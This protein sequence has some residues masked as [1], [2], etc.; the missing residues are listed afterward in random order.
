MRAPVAWRTW[1]SQAELALRGKTALEPKQ[2]GVEGEEDEGEAAEE[3][4]PVVA[5]A[6]VFELVEENLMQL[7]R[8]Q[9]AE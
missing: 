3:V 9:D 8:G 7:G 2:N 1:S 4:G 6:E 5:T